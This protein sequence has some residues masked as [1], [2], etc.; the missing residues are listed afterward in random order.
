MTLQLA[1]GTLQ[2]QADE[3]AE[4]EPLSDS[5][6]PVTAVPA[7]TVQ[8]TPGEILRKAGASLATAIEFTEL[9]LSVAK[10]ESGLRQEA[11]SPK[12]AKGLMQLMPQ[13][14]A[15]LGVDP[16]K[17]EQNALGGATYLREL[18]DRYRNNAVLALAA[19]NAG[20]GAVEKYGG[21]PPY[22]ETQHY[23]ERVLRE[24]SRLE[25][26]RHSQK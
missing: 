16:G 6:A 20:P 5:P 14:A 21:V 18:L 9:V 8:S 11:I 26:Q 4:I 3:I 10:V 15:E 23:I 17:A 25:R 2:F 1:S 22:F 24:Y 19:Y 7:A 12:G 13:T